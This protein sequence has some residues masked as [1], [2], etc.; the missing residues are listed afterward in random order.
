ME[1]EEEEELLLMELSGRVHGCSE[2]LLREVVK[3]ALQQEEPD[4]QDFLQQAS[5]FYRHSLLLTLSC[6]RMTCTSGLINFILAR[7][8]Q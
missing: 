7:A 6:E 3:C 1:E 4:L 2:A 8:L 5:R